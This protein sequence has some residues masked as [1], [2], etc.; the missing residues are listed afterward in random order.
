LGYV[1]AVGERLHRDAQA[2]LRKQISG[3]IQQHTTSLIR[4]QIA[5]PLPAR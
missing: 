4:R 5:F 3:G 2:F 1:H